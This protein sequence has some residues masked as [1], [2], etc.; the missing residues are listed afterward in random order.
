MT[1]D[2]ASSK[3]LFEYVCDKGFEGTWEDWSTA[4]RRQRSAS[5]IREFCVT[6][7]VILYGYPELQEAIKKACAQ[8][9]SVFDHVHMSASSRFAHISFTTRKK[10]TDEALRLTQLT[11]DAGSLAGEVTVHYRGYVNGQLRLDRTIT[12]PSLLE[13]SRDRKSVV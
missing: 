10:L 3:A 9:F 2:H 6:N 7:A 8:A 1:L 4:V 11:I 13:V 12:V 5:E